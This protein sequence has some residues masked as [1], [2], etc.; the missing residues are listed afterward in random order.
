VQ[1]VFGQN[2]LFIIYSLDLP[3]IKS[4]I[5]SFRYI[6]SSTISSLLSLNSLNSGTLFG[7]GR[8]LFEKLIFSELFYK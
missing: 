3:N 7:D 8:Y 1:S 2:N 5:V 4:I 6:T